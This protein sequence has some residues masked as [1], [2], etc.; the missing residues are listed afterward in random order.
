MP[1]E[2]K[3]ATLAQLSQTRLVGEGIE[4]RR[5]VAAGV[6]RYLTKRKIDQVLIS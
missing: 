3:E 4:E 5:K 2:A 1:V 6:T